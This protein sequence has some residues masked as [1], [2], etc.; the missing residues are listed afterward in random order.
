MPQRRGALLAWG[1]A[2]ALLLGACHSG[3]SGGP[4][5][6]GGVLRVSV[7]DLGSLD[8]A[9]TTGRGGLLAIEQLFDS[10][11]AIDPSTGRAIPAA[12]ASWAT[13]ADGLTWTFTLGAGTFHDG[14][15]VTAADFKA[16]FDRIARK[17]TGSELA[18]QLESVRGFHAAKIAGTAQGLDGVQAVNDTTLKIVLDRP[19]A[20]LPV[21]LA[22]PALGP[23]P[24]AMA[25]NPALLQQQPI[26]NGPFKMAGPRTSDRVVLER[27]DAHAGRTAYLD[28]MEIDL[29]G[30]GAQA[31]RDFLAKRTDVAEVP[32]DALASGRGRAGTGGFTPYW[33]AL[34]Y[35]PNLRSPKFAKPEFRKA[36]SLA[37]DRVRIA[38]IVYG[39]TK[40]PATGMIPRGVTGYA[41][42]S[43]ADC[44]K[45]T[46]RARQL[47]QTA[48]G[49]KP[50]EVIVDHLDDLTQEKLAKAIVEDLQ[51]VG[52]RASL[53]S[54]KS[55]DY[56]AFL[57]SG[58]HEL[59]EYGWLS[60]VP[61]PD[62]F[63][64]QQLRT[65]SVNNHTGFADPTF[66]SL[67]DQAR[68]ASDETARID[69][70]RKAEA[71]ALE[72]MPLIPIVFFRN[73]VGVAGRVHGLRIDGAGLFDAASVW[74]KGS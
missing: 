44:K 19:F 32:T 67:I 57:Q 51:A 27:F 5:V 61:S 38:D 25:A 28:R 12:A 9:A 50:P 56:L 46:E 59:A 39:G 14:T 72:V 73:H 26:G 36:I 63:L 49:G 47:I 8:P 45:D 2:L 55:K 42:D 66:D 11:T 60:E 16:A 37:I 30:D 7:R 31:W 17:S 21:F 62:G 69:A 33:A 48:F 52:L 1:L 29:Q 22:H 65:G 35:G 74:V 64:A 10:L 6:S 71:R 20:E 3:G 34:Y 41:A 43:C 15:P 24:K 70:Y 68:A 53:R 13:S 23:L 54:H 18:F 4:P 40:E 58:Q